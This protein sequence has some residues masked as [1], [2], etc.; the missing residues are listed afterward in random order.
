MLG[1]FWE[2]RSGP[3]IPLPLHRADSHPAEQIVPAGKPT[4]SG[5]A[6]LWAGATCGAFAS[7]HSALMVMN[8]AHARSYSTLRTVAMPVTDLWGSALSMRWL[9]CSSIKHASVAA[10][11]FLCKPCLGCCWPL[12]AVQLPQMW[13]CWPGKFH[14]ERIRM[15]SKSLPVKIRR[16]LLS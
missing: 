2:A 8:S 13:I 9:S 10:L 11:L 1:S 6:L 14:G 5:M 3:C 4:N 16:I 12:C 7:A 15:S